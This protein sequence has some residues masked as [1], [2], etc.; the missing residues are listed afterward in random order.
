MEKFEILCQLKAISNYAYDI[1]YNA[2]GRFFY[3]DHIFSERLADS[4]VE[5]DYIETLFL[6]ESQE[7][8][9]SAEINARVIELT[10]EISKDMDSNFKKLRN[11]ITAV[12][13]GI[14]QYK[15]KTRAEDDIL[16]SIAHIL[17]RHNGLLY[18]QLR[19]D[20]KENSNDEDVKEW[21]TVRGSHIPIVKGESK[22]EA[23]KEFFKSKGEEGQKRYE[24]VKDVMKRAAKSEKTITPDV[25]SFTEALGGKNIGLDFRLKEEGS[26]MR[27]L[28]EVYDDLGEQVDEE[29]GLDSMWDLVRY[30]AIFDKSE[31]KEK[32]EKLIS[33]MEKKGYKVYAV[34]NTWNDPEN[35]YKGVNV[36]MVSG[37][38]QKFELQLHTEKN[39]KIKEK[40]HKLYEKY[41]IETNKNEKARIKGQ[42]SEIGKGYEKPEGIEGLTRGG[43]EVTDTFKGVIER[44]KSFDG[45]E[46]GTYDYKTGEKREFDKG[47]SVS[48]HQN[49]PD[50]SG[51]WKSHLGRYKPEE[52]DRMTKDLAQKYKAE[53]NVGMYEDEPEISFHVDNFKDAYKLMREFNQVSVWDWRN[54]REVFNKHWDSKQNPKKGA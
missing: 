1:H 48:F 28:K 21:I 7:A 13:I 5:D 22:E 6:G 11:M 40:M 29:H 49:E 36:K 37:D 4:D 19:Y 51:K 12:L 50:K 44:V 9:S 10:P 46:K 43:T 17:Q 27:K 35:P 41:R 16:G 3:S 20:T 25:K 23:I 30:T 31:L 34:K 26:A 54:G 8:P 18:R 33:D 53:V 2:E 15:P 39:F 38:G 47:Y 52:Y 45:R 24:G 14:E 32:G 42:M